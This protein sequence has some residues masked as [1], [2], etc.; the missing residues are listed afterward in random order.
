MK[1]TFPLENYTHPVIV[2]KRNNYPVRVKCDA[3]N[4]AVVKY[5][6]FSCSCVCMSCFTTCNNE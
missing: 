6:C 3:E 4:L 1:S 2:I 5:I